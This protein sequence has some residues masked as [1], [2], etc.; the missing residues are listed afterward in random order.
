MV[1]P[2]RFRASPPRIHSLESLPPDA[3]VNAPKNAVWAVARGV[4]AVGRPQL[5]LPTSPNQFHVTVPHQARINRPGITIHR[6]LSLR[7]DNV[8]RRHSIPVTTP[9]STLIDLATWLERSELE[10]A[11]NEADKRDLIDPE[12]LRSALDA[13]RRRPGVRALRAT[14]DRRTFR[15]TDSELERRFLALVHGAG[16]PRPETGRYV[17]GFKVDFYWPDLGLVVETDGLR[18]HR[19]PAQQARDRVRDHVHAIAGVT[20]I[21]FTHA[22]VTFEPEHVRATLAAVVRRLRDPAPTRRAGFTRRA[23]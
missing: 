20:S 2:V 23:S 15:L 12:A 17:N 3:V 19:T 8:T 21:R 7:P 1:S 22:Q 11:I 10:A 5:I 13:F 16:L 6:R 14:L 9:V 18:Y 4:Y